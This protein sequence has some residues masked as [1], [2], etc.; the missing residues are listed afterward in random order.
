MFV[1]ERHSPNRLDIRIEG[2]LDSDAMR[3]ALDSLEAQSEDIEQGRM[4]YR[5]QNFDLP[6]FG[7]L[8]VELSRL[9]SLFRMIGRFSRVAVVA[10]RKWLRKASEIEGKLLPGVDIRAFEDDAAAERWLEG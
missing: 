3:A 8:G 10:D 7:A 6:T 2:K 1:V 5:I 9:P 4:L